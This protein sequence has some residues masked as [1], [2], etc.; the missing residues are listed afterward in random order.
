MEE[1][2]MVIRSSLALAL[3]AAI[4]LA[5]IDDGVKFTGAA[6][7]KGAHVR[8]TADL[9]STMSSSSTFE[10]LGAEADK[11]ASAGSKSEVTTNLGFTFSVDVT[12]VDKD[13]ALEATIKI[14]RAKARFK[15]GQ[16]GGESGEQEQEIPGAGTSWHATRKGEQWEFEGEGGAAPDKEMARVLEDVSSRLLAKAPLAAV[17]DGKTLKI[18]D[19]VSVDVAVAKKIFVYFGATNAF[20]SLDL[21]LKTTGKEGDAPVAIFAAKAVAQPEVVPGQPPPPPDFMTMKLEGEIAVS[22]TN[23]FVLR[24]TLTGP[25][26]MNA[27]NADGGVTVTISGT[28]ESTWKYTATLR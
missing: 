28:G 20:Q 19:K 24:G 6:L 2:A 26:S 4:G 7:L 10:G 1:S 8:V 25:V 15:M 3:A 9:E 17:M 14:D 16:V 18:G 23:L 12:A 21:E 13:A 11:E 27:K 5:T 22:T